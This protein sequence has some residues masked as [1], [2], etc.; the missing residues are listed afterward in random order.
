MQA[1][2][3]TSRPPRARGPTTSTRASPCLS[4]HLQSTP[5]SRS[6]WARC[7]NIFFVFNPLSIEAPSF[8][9]SGWVCVVLLI[10]KQTLCVLRLHQIRAVWEHHSVYTIRI[11]FSVYCIAPVYIASHPGSQHSSYSSVTT[12]EETSGTAPAGSNTASVGLYNVCYILRRR[13]ALYPL[14]YPSPHAATPRI[15]LCGSAVTGGHSTH[16][17]FTSL[18]TVLIM[19]LWV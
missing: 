1:R 19:Y 15:F 10:V 2:P 12:H 11:V 13:A 18:C 5:I 6:R 17:I 8:Y 14:A 9:S 7:D 3:P 16:A 4:R